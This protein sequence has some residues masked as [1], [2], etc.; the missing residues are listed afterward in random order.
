[1]GH[2]VATIEHLGYVSGL[3]DTYIRTDSNIISRP[4]EDRWRRPAAVGLSN[5]DAIFYMGH[6]EVPL[7]DSQKADC[8]S[9]SATA[10]A[11]SAPMWR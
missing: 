9:S 10:T 3:W 4:Q 5:V 7:D 8:C 11:S 1:V 2:A 6:R